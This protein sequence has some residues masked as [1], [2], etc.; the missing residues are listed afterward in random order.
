[1]KFSRFAVA[2]LDEHNDW[3]NPVAIRCT[4]C[5]QWQAAGGPGVPG[6][7]PDDAILLSD[8]TEWAEQ[9]QCAPLA[10]T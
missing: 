10:V 5:G 7:H 8:L 4:V 6:L 2:G 1:M 9:H 3:D